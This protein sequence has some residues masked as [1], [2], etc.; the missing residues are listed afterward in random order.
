MAAGGKAD[1]PQMPVVRDPKD[2][3]RRSGNTLERLIFNHRLL[4]LMVCGIITV[5]LGFQAHRSGGLLAVGQELPDPVSP[6]G[7]H[8]EVVLVQ[9]DIASVGGGHASGEYRHKTL[10]A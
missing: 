5:L 3:D 7:K 1:L 9:L 2:F 6:F 10:F 8:L 4:I